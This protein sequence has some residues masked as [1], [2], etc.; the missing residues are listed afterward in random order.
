MDKSTIHHYFMRITTK[1]QFHTVPYCNF[2][3]IKVTTKYKVFKAL[4]RREG[5]GRGGEGGEVRVE[6]SGG[7]GRRV[8]WSGGEG[9]G[10]KGHEIN[11]L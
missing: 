10:G 1:Q 2:K 5:E 9:R 7:E 11:S 8:E 4:L 3:S 6:W